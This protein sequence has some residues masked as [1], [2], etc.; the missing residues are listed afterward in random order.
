MI[1]NEILH[2]MIRL[3]LYHGGVISHRVAVLLRIDIEREIRSTAFCS[4]VQKRI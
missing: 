4:A 1:N 2:D 3:Q